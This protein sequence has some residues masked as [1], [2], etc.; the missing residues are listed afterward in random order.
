[1]RLRKEGTHLN[2]DREKVTILP[3]DPRIGLLS[4]CSLHVHTDGTC[5]DAP[6]NANSP[7]TRPNTVSSMNQD[8]DLGELSPSSP[9]EE[10]ANLSPVEQPIPGID[11]VPVRCKFGSKSQALLS[12]FAW[13]R[14][15]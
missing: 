4:Y 15:R 13:C 12:K 8:D 1:V 14:F 3:K 10:D 6:H 9:G 5:R 2:R 7:T 11:G